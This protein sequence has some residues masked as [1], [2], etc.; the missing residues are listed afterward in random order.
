MVKVCLCARVC[1]RVCVCVCACVCVRVPAC[2]C[3]QERSSKAS[4]FCAS[5][6]QAIGG[7]MSLA[8]CRQVVSQA[9]QHF[10]SSETQAIC[11]ACNLSP[12]LGI[13][14]SVTSL[15]PGV[16]KAINP[17]ESLRVDAEAH[18]PIWISH[19]PFCSR[20]IESVRIDDGIV[21]CLSPLEAI[22]GELG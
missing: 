22:H 19:F 12:P 2:V 11:D 17:Q 5:L 7:L 4:S 6:L 3:F 20:F 9:P 8:L 16:P 14:C 10:N 18:E 13:I 1:V 15:D 21:V